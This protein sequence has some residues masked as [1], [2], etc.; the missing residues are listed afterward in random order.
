LEKSELSKYLELLKENRKRMGFAMPPVYPN[1]ILWKHLGEKGYLKV[2]LAELD[3][4]PLAG[5]G[6]LCFNGLITEIAVAQ[7]QQAID[8]KVEASEAIKWH[9]IKW[10]HENGF[11]TYD[12]A[13]VKPE[14]KDPKDISMYFFKEKFGGR[15]VTAPTYY[16]IYSPLRHTIYKIARKIKN[17]R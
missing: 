15:L 5:L 6:F 1:S 9:I 12:L 2:L 8:K 10:G 11:K 7:S 16:K 14:S 3:G 17:V 4:K 13:G